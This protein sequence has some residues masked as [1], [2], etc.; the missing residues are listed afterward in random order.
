MVKHG[1][2]YWLIAASTLGLSGCSQGQTSFLVAQVCLRNQQDVNQ[3][4]SLMHRVATANRMTFVDISS[5]SQDSLSRIDPEQAKI[6]ARRPA[7]NIGT[8]GNRGFGFSAE[9]LGLPGYE[10][11][12]GF[13]SEGDDKGA[14]EFASSAISLIRR[15]WVVE[16][17]PG[18]IMPS[19]T[20]VCKEHAR[21]L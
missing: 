11:V 14:R 10:I 1:P 8:I 20:V 7:V 3:F 13:T 4:V 5:Q 17:R 15:T 18:D 16:S 6:E 19:G 12:M 9:N 21:S 2:I